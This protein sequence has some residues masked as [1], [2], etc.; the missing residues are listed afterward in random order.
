MDHTCK[1]CGLTGVLPWNW[2]LPD[3]CDKCESKDRHDMASHKCAQKDCGNQSA[4]PLPILVRGYH[5]QKAAGILLPERLQE[6]H[7][8]SSECFVRWMRWASGLEMATEIRRLRDCFRRL[9]REICTNPSD[10]KLQQQMDII[11]EALDETP[12]E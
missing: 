10:E 9:E 11:A 12:D 2:P 3:L 6:H 4:T 5:P 7:F 8:C 1:Q